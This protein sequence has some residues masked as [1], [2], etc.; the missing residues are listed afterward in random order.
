MFRERDRKENEMPEPTENILFFFILN[1]LWKYLD[2]TTASNPNTVFSCL[3]NKMYQNTSAPIHFLYCLCL[4]FTTNSR[5]VV[6]KETLWLTKLKI[7]IICYYLQR[8]SLQP[9]I[10]IKDKMYVG[11][12]MI[13]KRHIIGLLY[14]RIIYISLLL[15][16]HTNITH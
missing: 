6:T 9:L 2:Y 4:L 14:I 10:Q 5:G 15:Y 11:F 16:R 13:E 3:L 8:R 12:R 1:Y 7:F